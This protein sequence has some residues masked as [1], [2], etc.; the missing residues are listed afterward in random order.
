MYF[1]QFRN[2]SIFFSDF[3]SCLDLK[4]G[5]DFEICLDFEIFEIR[6]DLNFLIFSISKFVYV[7]NL[8]KSKICLDFEKVQF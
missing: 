4:F 5:S 6:S 3:E 8:F 2:F 7:G 1:F